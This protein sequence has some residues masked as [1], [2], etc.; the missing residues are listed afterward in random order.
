MTFIMNWAFEGKGKGGEFLVWCGWVRGRRICLGFLIPQ[1]FVFV[2]GRLLVA[3]KSCLQLALGFRYFMCISP[4]CLF[5]L[6]RPSGPFTE[7]VF[8]GG[9]RVCGIPR[10][11]NGRQIDC[12]SVLKWP[13][14]RLTHSLAEQ[15]SVYVPGILNDDSSISVY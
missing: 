12:L 8:G 11:W 5:L 3:D 9:E 14:D 4:R 7:V 13:I 2:G 15:L 10:S 1:E 6:V